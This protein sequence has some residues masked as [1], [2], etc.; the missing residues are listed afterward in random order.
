MCGEQGKQSWPRHPGELHL[1]T[2]EERQVDELSHFGVGQEQSDLPDP[3]EGAGDVLQPGLA[4]PGGRARRRWRTL[5]RH[6]QQVLAGVKVFQQERAPLLPL[7]QVLHHR[8]HI[9][10]VELPE[11][12]ETQ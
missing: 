6:T 9:G 4:Q 3:R 8:L 5:P 7:L 11:V 12:L 2:E 1:Q 10:K